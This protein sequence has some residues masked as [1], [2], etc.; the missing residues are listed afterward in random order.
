MRIFSWFNQRCRVHTPKDL[1]EESGGKD[2]V[3]D[4]RHYGS[5]RRHVFVEFNWESIGS[6][7]FPQRHATYCFC[8][9]SDCNC[10][11]RPLHPFSKRRPRERILRGVARPCVSNGRRLH[12]PI[13]GPGQSHAFLLV[14]Q[15]DSCAVKEGVLT[16]QRR[17]PTSCCHLIALSGRRGTSSQ[18]VSQWQGGFSARLRLSYP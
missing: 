8:H 17:G 2:E 13:E 14:T 6:G 11:M 1:R 16:P 15:V 9:F 4:S 18:G 3:G 7:R 10:F 12:F 5:K